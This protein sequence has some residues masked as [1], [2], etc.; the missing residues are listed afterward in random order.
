MAN[1][2]GVAVAINTFAAG[3]GV[4]RI[5]G[6]GAGNTGQ[7]HQQNLLV[8]GGLVGEAFAEVIDVGGFDVGLFETGRPATAQTLAETVPVVVTL[9]ALL[10]GVDQ[11]DH[12]APVVR[13]LGINVDPVSV[14]AAGAVKLLAV[15]RPAVLLRGDFGDHHAQFQVANFRPAAAHQFAV[16][17]TAEP[18]A[19][20]FGIRLIQPV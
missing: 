8:V 16:N 20:R 9:N 18:A 7:R 13:T 11:H 19:T 4:R 1:L 12:V 10:M 6:N 5:A 14:Q 17:K 3:D 2:F 15:K